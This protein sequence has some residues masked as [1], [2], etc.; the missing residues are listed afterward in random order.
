MVNKEKKELFLEYARHIKGLGYRVIITD[1]EDSFYGWIVNDNDEI[2][3]FQLSRW[4][5]GIR[6]STIHKPCT[7]FASGFSCMKDEFDYFM[8]EELTRE[9]VD[10]CFM[11]YPE[12]ARGN[13]GAIKKWSAKEYL[14]K[15]W[16][17]EHDMEI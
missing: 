15:H 12:W 16:G 9:N 10:K 8:E 17:K 14:E 2:G 13:V 6:L 11:R 5:Y 4:G 1:R 3:Y 7:E